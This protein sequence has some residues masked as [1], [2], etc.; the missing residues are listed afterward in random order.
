M[1][2]NLRGARFGALRRNVRYLAAGLFLAAACGQAAPASPTAPPVQALTPAAPAATATSAAGPAPTSQPAAA[3][4]ASAPAPAPAA[5]PLP[6]LPTVLPPLAT[7]GVYFLGDPLLMPVTVPTG[8]LTY[9]L[10][11]LQGDRESLPGETYPGTGAVYDAGEAGR[12]AVFPTTGLTRKGLYLLTYADLPPQR[13]L[14]VDPPPQVA[15]PL[16]WPF[17]LITSVD[18]IDQGAAMADEFYR[19]GLRWFHFDFPISSRFYFDWAQAHNI[20]DIGR[21]SDPDAGRISPGFEAFLNR[22]HE[23]GLRPIFK[24]VNHYTD[25]AE[26]ENP[27]GPFY[28][29]LRKIQTYYAGKIRYWTIGNEVEGGGYSK[30]SPE[31]YVGVLQRMSQTLKAVDPG[32]QIIAG[33]FYSAQGNQHLDRLLQPEYQGFWDVLSG[34]NTVRVRNGNAPPSAYQARLAAAGLTRPFWDTEANGTTFG[35]PSEY[36]GYMFSGFPTGP[37]ADLHSGVNKHMVRAFC[38]EARLGAAW[39]PGYYNPAEPCLGADLFIAMHYNANWEIQW[40][41]HRHW[42]GPLEEDLHDELNHKVADFRGITDLLY[43]ARGLTRIPNT[44]LPAAQAAT[45]DTV[46]TGADGYIY[47]VGAEYLVFLWRN[48]GDAGQDRE[49]VLE[50]DP[51]DR[52]WLV[53]SFGN[54]QPLR[55]EAG[56]VKVWV[57]AELVA[58]RGLTRLPTLARET[59]GAD[60]PYFVTE[61]VTQAVAGRPYFYLAQAYDSDA[62]EQAVDSLPHL[63]YSLVAGPPGLQLSGGLLTGTPAAPGEYSV[64]LRAESAHGAPQ[65]VEQTFTL[66]VAPA[67]T[68]LA[69]QFTSQPAALF[70]PPGYVWRYNADAQDPNGGPV[71]YSLAEAPAGMTID[72]ASGFIQWTPPAGAGGAAAVTVQASD[73]TQTAPQSFTV[74]AG[75]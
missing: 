51:A 56:R 47:R 36:T 3:A 1:P 66:T 34:H 63:T 65:A 42:T 15:D 57:P 33:E 41:V 8:S 14:L 68:D 44:D 60:A 23:L 28:A 37:D 31:E 21:S 55:N 58:V 2:P 17:G 72:A 67:E 9:T 18:K 30:F 13:V 19:I 45:P 20:N 71:T 16:T 11:W 12:L 59:T 74:W 62:P 22:A 40:A 48:T 39:V 7:G 24:L 53:D 5:G 32:V 6:A 4:T 52:V 35:G 29:G 75:P 27:D 46:Y 64:T 43:G 61:P 38:L 26:P 73:G 10:A 49:V 25:I 54:A 69:P 70:A 50:T